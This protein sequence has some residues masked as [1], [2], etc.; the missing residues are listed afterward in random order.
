[1]ISKVS[2]FVHSVYKSAPVVVYTKT[3]TN[4]VPTAKPQINIRM[5]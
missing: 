2:D 5:I 3:H 4:T 1:M